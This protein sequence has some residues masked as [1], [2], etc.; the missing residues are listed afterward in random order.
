MFFF[1]KNIFFFY[2]LEEVT[3]IEYLYEYSCFSWSSSE[4][5]TFWQ[6]CAWLFARLATAAGGQNE[7]GRTASPRQCCS[8]RARRAQWR[9]S[10][11]GRWASPPKATTRRHECCAHAAATHRRHAR[12]TVTEAHACRRSH[13]G[14]QASRA[15]SRVHCCCSLPR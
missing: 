12:A 11:L 8:Q 13:F 14:R 4:A 7:R 2:L 6:A 1:L 15:C 3:C 10:C 9:P 5:W